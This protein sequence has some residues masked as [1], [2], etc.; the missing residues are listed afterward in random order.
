M[1][2]FVDDHVFL[3]SIEE[4]L[5]KATHHESSCNNKYFRIIEWSNA[6]PACG[7]YLLKTKVN[8]NTKIENKWKICNH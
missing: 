2:L 4:D 6:L 7:K 8:V 1:L 3:A 5:R